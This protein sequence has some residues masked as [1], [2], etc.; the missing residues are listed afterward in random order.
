VTRGKETRAPKDLE[1]QGDIHTDRT[2]MLE[3]QVKRYVQ[4]RL[5]EALGTPFPF[6]SPMLE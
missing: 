2:G 5:E 4:L 6:V 3:A 1:W